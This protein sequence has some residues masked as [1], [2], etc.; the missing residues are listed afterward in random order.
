MRPDHASY[1]C[2]SAAKA[3]GMKIHFHQL[4]HYAA[5]QAIGAGF[6]PMAGAHRLGH[7]N[8]AMTLKIYAKAL[9]AQSRQIAGS[10]AGT[11]R[12]PERRYLNSGRADEVYV[13][14]SGTLDDER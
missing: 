13:I 3:T 1:L 10:L 4:R 14:V 6:D 8:P 5:T 12:L 7:A 11:V 9:P 2:D